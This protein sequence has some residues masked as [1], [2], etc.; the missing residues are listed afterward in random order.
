MEQQ[1]MSKVGMELKRLRTKHS[2]TQEQI[3]NDLGCTVSFISNIENNRA[4]LNL[5]VLLYYAKLCNVTLD[6]ILNAGDADTDEKKH[7]E[8]RDAELLNIVHQFSVE[9]QDKMI[10]IL[11]FIKDM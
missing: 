11:K 1:D 9:E 3:A 5:R 4:K 7:S 10:K 2:Y 6:S 8:A